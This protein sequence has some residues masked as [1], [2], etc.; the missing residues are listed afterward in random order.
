MS[1]STTDLWWARKRGNTHNIKATSEALLL[2][3]RLDKDKDQPIADFIKIDFSKL[4]KK[5]SGVDPI[6]KAKGILSFL[7]V[8][9]LRSKI[10]NFGE[11]EKQLI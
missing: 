9:G 3:G 11:K 1:N 7:F 2:K 4:S 6:G 5:S 8:N 10:R